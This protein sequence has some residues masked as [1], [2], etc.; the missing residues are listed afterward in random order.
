MTSVW[1]EFMRTKQRNWLL[2][3]FF[4]WVV[5]WQEFAFATFEVEIRF[6]FLLLGISVLALIF[7][8]QRKGYFF[9]VVLSFELWIA[10]ICW[11]LGK[12]DKD[13]SSL[14]NLYLNLFWKPYMEEQS[15][16]DQRYFNLKSPIWNSKSLSNFL[17]SPNSL[18]GRETIERKKNISIVKIW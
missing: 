4:C 1:V 12:L 6:I 8:H 15:P 5:Q 10:V 7:M 9:G 18:F 14:F 3:R 16:F 13:M 11:S 2:S 17:S